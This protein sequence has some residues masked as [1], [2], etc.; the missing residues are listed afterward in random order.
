MKPQQSILL[1]IIFSTVL[2]INLWAQGSGNTLFFDGNQN[3]IPINM[4]YLASDRIAE[5]TVM[6]WVKVPSG[7][8]SWAI[9][10]F[11]R[12]SNYILAI[13]GCT[14]SECAGG[15]LFFGTSST[16]GGIHD[17]QYT[18]INLADNQW[19]FVAASYA[20]G[21][22]KLYIDGELVSTVMAYGSSSLLGN[23][24]GE[25]TRYG[26]IGDGSEASFYN[27][28]RN[29]YYYRGNIDE[30][31]VFHAELTQTEIRDWMCRKM[32]SY[33]PQYAN[34]QLNFNFDESTDSILDSKNNYYGELKPAVAPPLREISGAPI[35][36]S[37]VYV[38]TPSAGSSLTM[39][40]ANGSSITV[41]VTSGSANALYI[42]GVNETP[43]DT[44]PPG[45]LDQISEEHY[46][47]VKIFGNSSLT[48]DVIYNYS[49]DAGIFNES[50][51][52]LC[53]RANNASTAWNLLS[54]TL[55]TTTNTL[56]LSG[57]TS[58]SE[59]ILGSISGNPLPV[60]LVNFNATCHQNT[61]HITWTT[62]SEI[63]NDFFIVEKSVN[64]H[65]FFE[66]ATIKGAGNS[67][68]AHVYNITDDNHSEKSTV[69]Y[70]LKQVDFDGSTTYHQTIPANCFANKEYHISIYPNP[71]KGLIT[72]DL[73]NL[74]DVSIAVKNTIG[75][76]VHQ[77]EHINTPAYQFKLQVIPGIY[78][79]EIST[80]NINKKY[81]LIME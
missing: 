65:D 6:A 16:S 33:H 20:A 58:D 64:G 50:N 25:G 71:N 55:N 67:N 44:I 54:S 77:T 26:I 74:K 73:D 78:F 21:I 15:F 30:L 61:T 32:S 31:R 57:Q 23:G 12:S 72:V 24:F 28:N 42:Y 76:L 48:Y 5:L 14:F 8:G 10:D 13:G 39:T 69:Y 60:E 56:T 49:G 11:D 52:R 75:Q 66:I 47:G 70:R 18:S 68:S 7:G 1:A 9:I 79:I 81:K 34:L 29:L 46:W 22:K 41:N 17:L 35:G 62:L 53:A 40:H 19:H 63:N 27:G 80:N 51:L 3:F 36:D 38:L 43:N 45:G 4:K 37:N 2:H 59:F